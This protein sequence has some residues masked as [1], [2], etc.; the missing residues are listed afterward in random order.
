MKKK[1]YRVV[2]VPK[3]GEIKVSYGKADSHDSPDVVYSYRGFDDVRATSNC[4]MFAF[5]NAPIHEGKTLRRILEERGFDITTL[6]FSIKK[7]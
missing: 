5:E 4:V 6:K 3:S 2:P 7:K 1:R